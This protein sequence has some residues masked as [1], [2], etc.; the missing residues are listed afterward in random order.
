MLS[1]SDIFN[2]APGLYME[3]SS[4][5]ADY[6]VKHGT[7]CTDHTAIQMYSWKI[8]TLSCEDTTVFVNHFRQNLL[9][10]LSIATFHYHRFWHLT[11]FVFFTTSILGMNLFGCKFCQT[12]PNGR[13]KC[14]RKNFDSLLWAIITV[15][16]VDAPKIVI[17]SIIHCSVCSSA[18]VSCIGNL[19]EVHFVISEAKGSVYILNT[20]I[21]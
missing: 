6:A 14:G 12:L 10:Y 13:R 20:V 17:S 21:S 11:Y 9:R 7:K 1:D 19:S 18:V 15:F 16:Q 8:W 5:Q 4:S 3:N 2:S